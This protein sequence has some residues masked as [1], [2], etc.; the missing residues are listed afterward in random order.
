MTSYRTLTINGILAPPKARMIYIDLLANVNPDLPWVSGTGRFDHISVTTPPHSLLFRA[1][2]TGTAFIGI[3]V[4]IMLL[5]R[6]W[7][8]TRL[9]T[10][11]KQSAFYPQPSTKNQRNIMQ[12]TS[13]K[14]IW[15]GSAIGIAC[16][17][18]VIALLTFLISL[19]HH[20]LTVRAYIDG[21]DVVKVSGNK[22]WFEHETCALP[23][24]TIYVNGKAWTPDWTNN[25]STEFMGLTPAFRSANA[26]DI[27][28][29]KRAGRGI[30]SIAQFPSPANEETLAVRLDDDFPGIP[31]GAD[32]YEV[33]ITW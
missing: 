9:P 3:G 17:A 24:R 4:L 12:T 10:N 30:V 28:I 18:L 26:H 7:R 25:V 15:I 20:K 29:T 2:V 31:G 19:S 6:F 33:V 13:H 5:V 22:L 21:R 14:T 27:Q 1:G 23:G 32:W 16:V 11:E 8:R